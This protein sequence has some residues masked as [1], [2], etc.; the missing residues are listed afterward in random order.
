M[1]ETELLPMWPLLAAALAFLVPLGIALVAAGGLP[2]HEARQVALTPTAAFVLAIVGYALVG[3]GLHYGG[4]GLRYDNVAF[5]PLV[6]EWSALSEEWGATWGM[7]GLAGFG[8]EGGLDTLVYL[9]VLSTL[10]WVTTAA[11]LPMIV[12]RGR[13]PAIVVALFGLLAAAIGFPI[14]GNWVQGGGWLANLGFNL[15]MGHGYVDFGGAFVFLL[16]G[17]AALAAILVFLDRWPRREG[18]A[19]LPPV[20]LPLLAVAGAGLIIVGS[21]GWLLA[22]PLADWQTLQPTRMLLNALLAAAGGGLLPLLYTWF[23]AGNPDSLLGARGLVA[24]WVA[25]LAAAPFV[26]PGAAFFIGAIAGLLLVLTTYVVD[27]RL[28]LQDR[29]GVL[30]TLGIPA[31]WGLLALGIFADGSAGAGY[32]G[33]GIDEYLGVAGQGVTGLRA[34]VGYVPDWT[35]QMQAQAVGV[36]TI[37]LLAFLATSILAVPLVIVARAWGMRR[38][39]RQSGEEAREG[40]NGR[41]DEDEDGAGAED[42]G[43]QIDAR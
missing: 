42:S 38:G 26:S 13:A 18:P 30:A 12:L 35:G 9:L 43:L 34:A 4:I 19:Q 41:E 7:A 23:A 36:A 8:L 28:C 39:E 33:V 20:H 1:A 11:L 24:G 10:P 5:D 6:W 16:G 3:F 29:G 32:N 2:A 21:T 37:F 31:L 27:H 22:W 17:A 40:A 14:V 15:G 25:G